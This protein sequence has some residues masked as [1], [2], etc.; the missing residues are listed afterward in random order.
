[1]IYI[2]SC[3]S[4]TLLTL[5]CPKGHFVMLR[6]KYDQSG[7]SWV[8]SAHLSWRLIRDLIPMLRHPSVLVSVHRHCPQFQTSPKPASPFKAKIL[9]EAWGL[10]DLN[11]YVA[12]G[13]PVHHSLFKWWPW[14]DL[15]LF[16]G[17]V[18]F[19][20]LSFAYRKK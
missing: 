8:S 3:Y 19:C 14:V 7:L 12:S 18:I 16:Y 2:L 15:D 1:M 9:Y 6:L 17:K 10:A 20:F 11:L 13:T 5:K 4:L